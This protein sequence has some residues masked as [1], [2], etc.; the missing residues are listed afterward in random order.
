[1]EDLLDHDA[2]ANHLGRERMAIYIAGPPSAEKAAFRTPNARLV[3]AA[4][5][6]GE[7]DLRAFFDG[8][9]AK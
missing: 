9:L 2:L 5:S 1:M 6:D 3:Q 7:A 4:V 8:A